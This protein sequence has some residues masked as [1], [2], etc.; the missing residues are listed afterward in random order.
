MQFKLAI[1]LNR[2]NISKAIC[3]NR[4]S[5]EP[6]ALNQ[7]NP[8]CGLPGLGGGGG[9]LGSRGGGYAVTL[10]VISKAGC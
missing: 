4:S 8:R 7:T 5:R 10:S 1:S 6:N 2:Q 3:S 9:S